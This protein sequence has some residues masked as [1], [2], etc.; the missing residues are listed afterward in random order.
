MNP[1]FPARLPGCLLSLL[2][3]VLLCA[4]GD[5][6]H[7][8]YQLAL[9]PTVAGL[10]RTLTCQNRRLDQDGAHQEACP[11]EVLEHLRH[12]YGDPE[13]PADTAE[14][15][16]G[17]TFCKVFP[18]PQPADLHGAGY[19]LHQESDLGSLWAWTERIGGD[20]DQA[21]I[22]TRA[23]EA[24]DQMLATLRGWL[25]KELGEEPGLGRLLAFWD[26]PLRSDAH[27]VVTHLFLQG[28]LPD[29]EGLRSSEMRQRLL[30]LMIERGYLSIEEIPRWKRAL[31]GLDPDPPE[32]LILQLLQ[33]S[34]FL[35]G[36]AARVACCPINFLTH[37]TSRR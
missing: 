1:P 27:N 29:P 11:E 25:A 32:P 5:C 23:L 20:D 3:W 21:E 22:L 8:H 31:D 26:G 34:W 7:Q 15:E 12:L 14:V 9:K 35:T 2:C 19:L 16:P 13:A 36:P 28:A 24:T 30:W 37:S 10:E 6:S 18:G 4:P 17:H 33:R